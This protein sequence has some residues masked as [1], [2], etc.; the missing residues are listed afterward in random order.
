MTLFDVVLVRLFHVV[1]AYVLIDFKKVL[2]H[3]TLNLY[4]LFFARVG[5]TNGK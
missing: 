1:R 3:H 5:G 4:F 2:T